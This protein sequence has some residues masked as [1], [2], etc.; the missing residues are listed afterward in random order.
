LGI[1]AAPQQFEQIG[2]TEV[3][4]SREWLHSQ[5]FSQ[6]K[7]LTIVS[8]TFAS[9]LPLLSHVKLAKQA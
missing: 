6:G 3:A 5:F 7:P 4:M 9:S 2:Q 1:A 8:L